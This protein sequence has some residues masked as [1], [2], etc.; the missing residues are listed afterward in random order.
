VAGSEALRDGFLT[1]EFLELH[2]VTML[3]T[4]LN[5][6]LG[7]VP[8]NGPWLASLV[9]ATLIAVEVARALVG[10]LSAPVQ[11]VEPALPAGGPVANAPP[12]DV[13]SIMSAH[14]FG[15]AA[16]NP[17]SQDPANAPP[18]TANLVL[19][20]TIA[21]GDPKHGVAI[22]SDGGP[23]KVYSVGEN[24][25]GAS[26]HSV[27][28][29]RVILDRAGAL[30][31]LVLPRTLPPDRAP[32]ARRMAQARSAVDN[33]RQMVQSDPLALN[34]ILR[35]V[36]SYD[37][38]AG[39]LRGFRVY[40]GRNRQAFSSLGLKPGDLVT[41]ING[42]PL[43]D[44]QHGQEVMNTIQSSDRASVTIERGGQT[45]ELT[46]NIA[47]VAAEA[48]RDI[49]AAPPS[50]VGS[51]GSTGGPT[52]TEAP[53]ISPQPAPQALPPEPAPTP[54]ADNPNPI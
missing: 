2:D 48:T 33:L 3:E 27:Y 25:G 32:I 46:L 42:T 51:G 35:P 44:P 26:L 1:L 37:N 19:A 7:R 13:Q 10:L 45:Q 18:S 16:L 34:E 5:Q 4:R 47:E 20:G 22:I 50:A 30:E 40:P 23:S 36:A 31:T 9:L 29:D 17:G 15:V 41:A 28:L 54:P 6:W 8:Q 39:K 43:D 24:V 21:T 53:S 11:P 12:M 52:G 14:L 49:A 38:K